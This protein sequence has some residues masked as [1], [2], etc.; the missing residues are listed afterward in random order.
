MKRITMLAWRPKETRNSLKADFY[1][2]WS[3]NW[4]K[5]LLWLMKKMKTWSEVGSKKE[6]MT[7]QILLERTSWS[8]IGAKWRIRGTSSLR[9]KVSSI[10]PP[11][12]KT[13][14]MKWE[15]SSKWLLRLMKQKLQ[16]WLLKKRKSVKWSEASST[17]S[18]SA[19]KKWTFR[20]IQGTIK[21]F[22]NKDYH[23][24]SYFHVA[25][26]P[27][28]LFWSKMKPKSLLTFSKFGSLCWAKVRKTRL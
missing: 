23:Y 7:F 10:C 11:K 18:I 19:K 2:S 28:L 21:I 4:D 26:M 15:F 13:K 20:I 5:A 6:Y 3:R 14:T 22:E 16:R 27:A 9:K 8:S 12:G 24:S 25:R 1:N 17:F